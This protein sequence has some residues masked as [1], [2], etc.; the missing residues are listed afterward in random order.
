MYMDN[1]IRLNDDTVA[2]QKANGAVVS[3]PD[4]QV[5]NA[6]FL[7]RQKFKGHT[8]DSELNFE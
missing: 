1:V 5:P 6:I 4:W 2:L 3:C 7:S 8:K